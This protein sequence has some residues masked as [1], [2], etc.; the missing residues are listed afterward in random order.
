MIDAGTPVLERVDG[1]RWAP[2]RTRARCEKIVASYCRHTNIPHYLPLLRRLARYQRRDVETFSPMFPS[3]IFVQVG[4]LQSEFFWR[5]PKLVS[6]LPVDQPQ[7][8]LLLS[9]LRDIRRLEE[10][11]LE[12]EITV[13]P[14]LAAGVKVQVQSGPL[15]GLTG[16]VERRGRKARVTINVE[17]LGQSVSAEFDLEDV[18]ILA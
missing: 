12:S 7:E 9:E 6:L 17:M 16:I 13:K 11:A 18:K 15:S 8:E 1:A 5:C 14:E 3:Y 10:A 2:V 4:K